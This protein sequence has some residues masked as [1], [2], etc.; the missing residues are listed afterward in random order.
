[1]QTIVYTAPAPKTTLR[2]KAKKIARRIVFPPILLWDAIKLGMNRLL[3]ASL[4]KKI[5]AASNFKNKNK[6]K[7]W[8]GDEEMRV[9]E[10][11]QP[12]MTVNKTQITT[13]D[14]A[15]LDGME[16]KMLGAEKYIVLVLAN[17]GTYEENLPTFKNYKNLEQCEM[18]VDI[19][20][21]NCNYVVFNYRNVSQS[22]GILKSQNN[23]ITDAIAQVQRLLD[24]DVPPGMIYLKGFSVGSAVCTLVAYHFHKLGIHINCFDVLP[25]SSITNTVAGFIRLK[26]EK[27]VKGQYHIA[28]GYTETTSGKIKATLAYPIIKFILSASS[29][30]MSISKAY[31]K[32][33]EAHKYYLVV[34]SSREHRANEF[35]KPRDD[36]IISYYASLH[37]A[38]K[39]ERTK[40][41]AIL[42]KKI[43]ALSR[44][45]DNRNLLPA[46]QD[47]L[48]LT[49]EKRLQFKERKVV[50]FRAKHCA[51]NLPLALLKDRRNNES[52]QLLFWK[53]MQRNNQVEDK[54]QT[55]EVSS[56]LKTT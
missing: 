49:Q 46:N 33:P 39:S 11:Y 19:R 15:V 35:S 50:S 37:A 18:F 47:E 38:L 25:F 41:K 29:W 4:G 7:N 36:T 42:D 30:D 56:R 45:G 8:F 31:Q 20:V 17:G 2:E 12:R 51:H 27:N 55:L 5:I 10:G 52:A 44:M 24:N 3:G 22:K 21:Q 6:L 23:I 28:S 32:L 40:Q 14:G 13:H 16:F 53:F 43:M 34:K 48:K 26:K 54:T 1:M 9:L